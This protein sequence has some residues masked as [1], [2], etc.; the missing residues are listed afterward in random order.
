MGRPSASTG[1]SSETAVDAFCEDPVSDIVPRRNPREVAAPGV[2]HE[3]AR[4]VEVEKE[5]SGNRTK[6]GNHRDLDECRASDVRDHE[7][8]DAREKHDAAGEAIEPIDEVN[9]VCDADDP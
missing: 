8:R 2:T 3:D 4:R 6:H 5:K 1:T 9:R 7:V